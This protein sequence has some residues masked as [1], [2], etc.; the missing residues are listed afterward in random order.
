[1]TTPT[2][3]DRDAPVIARHEID[4]NAPLDTVWRLQT[5]VNGWPGWQTKA[6]AAR[7]YYRTSTRIECVPWTH[8][9]GSRRLCSAFSR[10]LIR[11][12][13]RIN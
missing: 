12:I 8:I 3:I 9:Y 10:V 11:H 6:T 7:L 5:D 2:G 4:I 13:G 1:M